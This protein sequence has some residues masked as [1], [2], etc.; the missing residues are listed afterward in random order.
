MDL[1]VAVWKWP[2]KHGDILDVKKKIK[3]QSIKILIEIK[4]N[5]SCGFKN[6]VKIKLMI[7]W[8]N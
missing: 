7:K 8:L 5:I 6:Y 2:F 4:C 3:S 1:Y